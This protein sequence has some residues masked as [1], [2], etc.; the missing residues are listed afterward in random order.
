MQVVPVTIELPE[1]DARFI[2]EMAKHQGVTVS[3]IME[4]YVHRLRTRSYPI[5]PD[6]L[7]ITGLLP[8]DLDVQQE[9]IQPLA[10]DL[11]RLRPLR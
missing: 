10:P 2:L 8:P 9:Y 5:H 1:D 3:E 6:V 4:R 7:A 11:R